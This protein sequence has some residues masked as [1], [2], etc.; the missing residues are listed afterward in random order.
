MY[1]YFVCCRLGRGSP[2]SIPIPVEALNG[3]PIPLSLTTRQLRRRTKVRS[4][5]QAEE[6]PEPPLEPWLGRVPHL[7]EGF[8]VCEWRIGL[9]D[10]TSE[11]PPVMHASVLTIGYHLIQ[12]PTHFFKV[13][14]AVNNKCKRSNKTH[15]QGAYPKE[16]GLSFA[17]KAAHKRKEANPQSVCLLPPILVGGFT[18]PNKGMDRDVTLDGTRVPLSLIEIATGLDF[19]VR[20]HILNI[21]KL[22]T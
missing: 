5:T 20:K 7:R 10:A 12:V 21:Q 11:A 2:Y 14:V 19:G 8:A 9:E 13:I 6:A 4:E 16:E 3:L 1:V 18:I 15:K 17:E 22:K